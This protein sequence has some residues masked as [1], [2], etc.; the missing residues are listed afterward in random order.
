MYPL[1]HDCRPITCTYNDSTGH[2]SGF[3]FSLT[4]LLGNIAQ[5]LGVKLLVKGLTLINP[6]FKINFQTAYVPVKHAN[7][8]SESCRDFFRDT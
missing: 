6:K 2:K 3:S 1:Y 8:S 7:I 5:L 4:S